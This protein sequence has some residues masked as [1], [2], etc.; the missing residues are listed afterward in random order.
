MLNE[1]STKKELEL[2]FRKARKVMDE[3]TTAY[4]GMP[5][6]E[7]IRCLGRQQE[8]VKKECQE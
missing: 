8:E 4:Y 5:W 2:T 7:Y 6:D 1:N 3:L